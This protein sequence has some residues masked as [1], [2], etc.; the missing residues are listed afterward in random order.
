MAGVTIPAYGMRRGYVPRK[1]EDFG[2]GGAF[3]EIHIVQFPRNMGKKDGDQATGNTL[4]LVADADGSVN[5]D[6]I[7]TQGQ[8]RGKVVHSGLKAMT[9]KS[10]A[11]EDAAIEGRPDEKA[12]AKITADTVHALETIV[13]RKI[14]AAQ[15]AKAAGDYLP[16]TQAEYIRYTPQQQGKGHNSGAQQRIIRMVEQQVDPLE[17]P[18]FKATKIP[19]GPPSP[20]APVVH[21]PPRKLTKEDQANWKIPPCVSNWKNQ[22]GFAIPLDKRLAADGRGLLDV[23]INDKFA[24]LTESLYM[25]EKN[26]R[27]EVEARA[28]LQ[29]AKAVKEREKMDERMREAAAD[30]RAMRAGLSAA[31]TRD[32]DESEAESR[33]DRD[34][35][36]EER[37]RERERDFRLE[38][39]GKKTKYSR[40]NQRDISEKIALGQ[41]KGTGG[42]EMLYD[43]RLFNQTSGLGAGF[44]DEGGY[45][46]YDKPLFGG[47]SAQ[48]IY[49]PTK[50]AEEFTEEDLDKIVKTDR[51]RPDKGFSGTE[52][53]GE[54]RSGPVQFE[55]EADPFGVDQFLESAKRGSGRK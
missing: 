40:D 2:D 33:R 5:F 51:F 20:P 44:G 55:K 27:M 42:G 10:Q 25:A 29:K 28:K 15:P 36:R 14:S 48:Q 13:N 30:A 23:Q 18:K 37:R 17:P 3:P 41:A 39:A 24:S 11:E 19:A 52:G 22:K 7:V 1:P 4:A 21:S 54:S 16:K 38:Q 32:E 47:T 26:S 46:V 9:E 12:Q 43:Q 53:G 50:K 8:R 35:I 34:K 45:N 6:A 49:K 31:A